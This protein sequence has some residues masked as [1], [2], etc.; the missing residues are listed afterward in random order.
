MY[1]IDLEY[2]CLTTENYG[3]NVVIEINL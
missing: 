1:V 2:A 3:R